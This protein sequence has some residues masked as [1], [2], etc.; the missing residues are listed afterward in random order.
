LNILPPL[1][2]SD[3]EDLPSPKRKKKIS[4]PP[5]PSGDAGEVEDEY[6]NDFEVNC[7][8]SSILSLAR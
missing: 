5:R 7:I 3:T 6:E 8:V 1:V 4:S 2:I